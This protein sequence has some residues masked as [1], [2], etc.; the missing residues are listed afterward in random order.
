M[1]AGPTRILI[2]RFSSI[3]D[4]VLTTPF[5]RALHE[6]LDGPV[7]IHYLTK[8]AFAPLLESNPR[9]HAVHT[10]EKSVQEILPTLE[11][12]DF[13]YIIDLHS[14]IR[15]RVVK[16]KLKTLSFQVNKENWRKWLLVR[17]GWRKKSISHIVDR[18]MDTLRA[19]R[20]EPDNKGLEYYIPSD[21][22]ITEQMK[23]ATAMPFV[24]IA[25]GATHRGKRVSENKW[26]ELQKMQDYPA[27]LI[28]GPD[29]KAL[30]QRIVQASSHTVINLCGELSLHQSAWIIAQSA[31]VV[32][33]D[34][35][36]MHVGSAFK[37][38]IVSLWGCTSPELGMSPYLP[39]EYSLIIEPRNRKRRPCS[40]LGDR[41][42]YGDAHRC[43]EQLSTDEIKAA[44]EKLWA[45]RTA[46]SAH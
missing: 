34:T 38:N 15:S 18:Y 29:E 32:S 39:G 17:F 2:I 9:I 30:A 21:L 11:K 37:K 43:I 45:L 1:Q 46:P 36:M 5:V 40:K 41:C 19:F 28:G 3:G 26:V 44:I 13:D 8:K 12:V 14:N 6:Q 20:C 10:I 27:V 23:H 31:V 42:K 16:R 25:L 35:G 22:S 24:V 7:E 33:G 4:I